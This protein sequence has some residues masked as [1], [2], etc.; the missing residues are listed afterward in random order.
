MAVP[1]RQADPNAV[2]AEARTFFFTANAYGKRSLFQS[3]RMA[4]LLIEV[5]IKSAELGR[6][7]L[8]AF[9]VMPDHLHALLTVSSDMTIEKAAQFVK[10]GFSFRAKR[11]LG[12]SHEIWQAGYSEEQVYSLLHFDSVV[13]YIHQNPVRRR[14]VLQCDEFRFSSANINYRLSGYPAHLR[15]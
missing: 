6:F 7:Q 5:M 1:R 12:Y 15:G 13:H 14:L 10:G 4:T 9:V 3:D 2:V 11:E 8:H